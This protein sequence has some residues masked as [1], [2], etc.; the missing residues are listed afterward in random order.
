MMSPEPIAWEPTPTAPV[1]V[2]CWVTFVPAFS[3][4]AMVEAAGASI[5]RST[6]STSQ[7]PPSPARMTAS[8]M[9]IRCP[10]VSTRPPPVGPPARMRAP[11]AMVVTSDRPVAGAVTPTRMFPPEFP[12]ASRTAEPPTVTLRPDRVMS[13]PASPFVARALPSTRTSPSGAE[14]QTSP[15]D[16]LTPVAWT[17]PARLPART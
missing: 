5:V 4:E 14:S 2:V 10:E 16:W 13:P 6:G 15:P 9:V 3:A 11:E 12:V 7:R 8:P 1:A 17:V